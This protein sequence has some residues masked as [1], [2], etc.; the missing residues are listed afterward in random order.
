MAQ[1][2]PL[3]SLPGSEAY[4]LYLDSL[5]EEARKRGHTV[6][7]RT[8]IA[9]LALNALGREWGLEPPRRSKPLGWNQHSPADPQ[10]PNSEE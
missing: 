6:K 8:G 9:E 10:A 7:G 2:P 5:I 4:G 1:K 3:L